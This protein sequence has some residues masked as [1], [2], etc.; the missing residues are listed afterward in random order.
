[1]VWLRVA[2]DMIQYVTRII[3]LSVH[4]SLSLSG[5]VK[6]MDWNGKYAFT[7]TDGDRVYVFCAVACVYICVNGI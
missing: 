5:Y 1:M 2:L 4:V 7:S 3:D 6:Q